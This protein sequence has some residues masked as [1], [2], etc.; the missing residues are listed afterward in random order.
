M[1]AKCRIRSRLNGG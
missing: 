1:L